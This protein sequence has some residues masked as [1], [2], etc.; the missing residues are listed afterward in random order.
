MAN[1]VDGRDIAENRETV[2]DS[3]QTGE[4]RAPAGWY[5]DPFNA[6]RQRYWAGAAW[7]TDIRLTPVALDQTQSALEP[8]QSAPDDGEVWPP[9][10]EQ[11]SSFLP[12]VIETTVGLDLA[13]DSIGSDRWYS[14]K[15]LIIPIM[16]MIALGAAGYLLTRPSD[17][18]RTA[19][20]LSVATTI[21]ATTT[22]V[23]ATTTTP[24]TTTTQAPTT[25]TTVQPTTTAPPT[26]TTP[27]T[28]QAAAPVLSP[29][30][31]F[32][33]WRASMAVAVEG[34]APPEDDRSLTEANAAFLCSRAE[35]EETLDS[36]VGFVRQ[37]FY[38]AAPQ[39]WD[40]QP[41][42]LDGYSTAYTNTSLDIYC[43]D[44]HAELLQR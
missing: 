44:I 43:P 2:D 25:T 28:T 38:D 24:A 27:P 21:Q 40:P 9:P 12:A 39:R 7:T 10:I 42:L 32:E 37:F 13:E 8:T 30:E 20:A 4:K 15:R 6:A 1:S 3:A 16:L 19:D 36:L 34:G 5:P 41:E 22:T 31:Q 14:A 33:T 18:P 17:V 11:A 35:G 23:A 26:T 29:E